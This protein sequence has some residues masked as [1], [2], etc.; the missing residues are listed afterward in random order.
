MR[1]RFRNAVEPE[2][3]FGEYTGYM[4]PAGNEPFF[5]INCMTFR[6]EPS[7][8]RLSARCRRRDTS[9]IRGIGR[10]W[11]LFKHLR[12]T[13]HI[14]IKD[15]RLEGSRGQRR[16]FGHF[17]EKTV[18]WS[19][20]PAHVRRVVLTHAGFGKITVVVDDDIDVWDDF[21]V[22]WALSWRVRPDEDVSL[23]VTS[24]PSP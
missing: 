14:P 18:R 20:T 19:G 6:N 9:R 23:N 8:K 16:I 15:L 5:N 21:A 22:D 1:G 11:P 24:R 7:S 2:G 13:L 17:S 3:P 12:D 10:E 4:G